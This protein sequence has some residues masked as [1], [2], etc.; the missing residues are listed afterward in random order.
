MR[1]IRRSEAREKLDAMID[2][3]VANRAPLAITRERAKAR[4]RSR[5]ARGH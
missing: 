5:R 4:Y 3:V 2:K 1:S